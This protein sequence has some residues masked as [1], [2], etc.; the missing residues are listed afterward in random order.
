MHMVP[1]FE[2]SPELAFAETRCATIYNHPVLPED[3]YAFLESFCA[4][5]ACDC[6]RVF[7]HVVARNRK[8]PILATINYGWEDEAFYRRWSTSGMIEPEE[9]KGPNLAIVPQSRYAPALL[10]VFEEVVLDEDYVKR[11]RRHYA[12][13]KESCRRRP[14]RREGDL[15]RPFVARNA[16]CPCGSRRKFKN[17][18]GKQ[19]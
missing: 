17:C 10:E 3:E 14:G 1:F 13:F 8:G 19:D 4:D 16:P 12:M 18:C 15:S 6:R 11:L 9:L 2:R 5:P 7:V